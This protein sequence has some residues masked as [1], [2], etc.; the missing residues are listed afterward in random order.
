MPK[1]KQSPAKPRRRRKMKMEIRQFNSFAEADQYDREYWWSR[2]PA[3]RMRALEQL[4]QHIW[5]YGNGKPFPRLERILRIVDMKTGKILATY[6][7]KSSRGV[8]R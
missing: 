6:R 3:Y 8:A 1:R 5:G 4:R 7:G 2:T